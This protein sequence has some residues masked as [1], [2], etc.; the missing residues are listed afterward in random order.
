[1]PGDFT[2]ESPMRMQNTS[3][4]ASQINSTNFTCSPLTRQ[5][6]TK[7]EATQRQPLSILIFPTYH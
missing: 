3:N 2:S 5:V 7:K 1:M 4:Y 6:S